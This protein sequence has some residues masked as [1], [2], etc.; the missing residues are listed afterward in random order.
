MGVL[1]VTHVSHIFVALEINKYIAYK[2]MYR[3]RNVYI[4]M[5]IVHIDYTY[6]LQVLKSISGKLMHYICI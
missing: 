1:E 4:Y 2:Y 3:Y 6:T 5:Y